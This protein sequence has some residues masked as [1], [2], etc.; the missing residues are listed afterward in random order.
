MMSLESIA[1]EALLLPKEQRF[2]LAHR[3][4]ASVE[5]DVSQEIEAAW[6]EEI[7][8]RIS[9]YDSGASIGIPGSEVFREI[10]R[11]LG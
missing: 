9:K 10:D 4:L 8:D 1:S 6:D 11:K 5:P 3:L 2:T 7:R